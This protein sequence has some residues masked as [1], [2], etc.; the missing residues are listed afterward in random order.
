MKK[1]AFAICL[2]N[3]LLLGLLCP[4]DAAQVNAG[5]ASRK[6]AADAK[7][8][9]RLEIAN[10]S[11]PPG[12][13]VVLPIYFT[14]APGVE[15]GRL[16]LAVTFESA[17]LKF[18]KLEP[19]V[20]APKGNFGLSSDLKV[21]KSEKGLETATLTVLAS[22]SSPEPPTKGIPGGMLGYLTLRI[23]EKARPGT[24][25]LHIVAE[26]DEW[27]SNTPLK[28]LRTSHAHVEVAWVD[29]PPS[30]SCFFFSH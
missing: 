1:L 26:G 25:D 6:K 20:A 17:N 10:N 18:V 13:V 22:I 3:I 21:S 24:I 19:G 28:N 11:G 15:A 14:P 9:T 16:K 7:T 2:G 23:S 29:A 8:T 27:G 5:K 30:I 4:V 12:T